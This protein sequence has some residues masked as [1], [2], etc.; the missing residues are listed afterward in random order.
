M[1]TVIDRT[2]AGEFQTFLEYARD[3]RFEDSP[4]YA[5]L[6][7]RVRGR[8]DGP[9]VLGLRAMALAML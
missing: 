2:L 3:L 8:C 5:Y 4:D 7:V 9:R 1:T 6:K